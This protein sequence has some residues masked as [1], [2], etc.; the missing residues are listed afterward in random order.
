MLCE[1][2]CHSN[3]TDGIPSVKQIIER[4]EHILGAIAVTDHNTIGG[5]EAAKKIKSIKSKLLIIP[6]LE[7][8]SADGHIIALGVEETVERDQSAVDTVDDIHMLGGIAIAAHPFGEFKRIGVKD[9]KILKNFDAIEG[10]N[11]MTFPKSNRK[12]LELAKSV[13]KPITSGSDAHSLNYVGRYACNID[14]STVEE[15]LH[16]IKKG[17]VILPA[18]NTNTAKVLYYKIRRNIN[19]SIKL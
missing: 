16:N 10:I 14:G 3:L 13:H 7:I 1:L 6:G 19:Q 2:H 11:G 12:A 8:T 17:K 4:A 15:I 18:N 9:P 5:Y